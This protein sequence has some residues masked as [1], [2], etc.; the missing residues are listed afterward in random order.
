VKKAVPSLKLIIDSREQLPLDFNEAAFDEVE[1][2][3][4]PVGDYWAELDGKEIPLCFER[5]S[6]GD[7]FSTMTTGYGRFK[8]ELARAKEA[9]LTVILVIEGSMREVAAGYD[10]SRYKGDSM[11]KKLAMLRVRYDLEFHFFN[12]RREM[13]RYIEEIFSAIRRSWSSKP[14]SVIGSSAPKPTDTSPTK[15][16]DCQHD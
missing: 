4:M 3:G 2:R 10:Y 7:L 15:P 9:G 5:K 13:S 12:D 11:L 1:V 8:K 16:I 14:R 6:L